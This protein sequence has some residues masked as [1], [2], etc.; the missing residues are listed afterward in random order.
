MREATLKLDFCAIC[1]EMMQSGHIKIMDNRNDVDVASL[2]VVC[3][4]D[5][6]LIDRFTSQLPPISPS[7]LEEII[8]EC[9][10]DRDKFRR[11]CFEELREFQFR[12]APELAKAALTGANLMQTELLCKS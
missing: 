5:A 4:D 1:G 7:C 3:A 10:G 9:R 2:C 8:Y 6:G 11:R 12:Y